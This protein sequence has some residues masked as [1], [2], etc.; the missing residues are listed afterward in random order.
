MTQVRYNATLVY[1]KF[2]A[3]EWEAMKVAN[4]GKNIDIDGVSIHKR[5]VTKS[6]YHTYENTRVWDAL[7]RMLVVSKPCCAVYPEYGAHNKLDSIIVA[8]NSGINDACRSFTEIIWAKIKAIKFASD[9]QGYTSTILA[10]GHFKSA[11]IQGN[12]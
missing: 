12:N 1:T 4:I 3:T 11:G 8:F 7:A 10:F 2:F 5:F 6:D 9:R